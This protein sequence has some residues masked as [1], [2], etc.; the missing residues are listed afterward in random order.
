MIV[1]LNNNN[2]MMC[3]KLCMENFECIFKPG[4]CQYVPEIA[5]VHETGL[6]VCSC[7]CVCPPSG[8]V[9]HSRKMKPE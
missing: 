8:Y 3:D 1:Y 7:V 5:F 9:K 6:F 4:V 2:H